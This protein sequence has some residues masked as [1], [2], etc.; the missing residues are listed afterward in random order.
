MPAGFRAASSKVAKKSGAEAIHPGYGFL[1]ENADFARA[2][3]EA[4]I[5]FIGPPPEAIE[6]A[7]RRDGKSPRERELARENKELRE[8]VSDLSIRYALADRA[9]KSRPSSPGRS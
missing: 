9:L 4:G 7:F 8:V 6:D 5:V 1:A 2:C 3:A